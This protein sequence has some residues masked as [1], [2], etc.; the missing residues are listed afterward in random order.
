MQST[1]GSNEKDMN[2]TEQDTYINLTV[3]LV[4]ILS[5]YVSLLFLIHYDLHIVSLFD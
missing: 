1:V 2:A 3:K 4:G 5:I